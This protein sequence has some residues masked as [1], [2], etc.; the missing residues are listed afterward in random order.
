MKKIRSIFFKL[1]IAL[2]TLTAT[3]FPLLPA[4]AQDMCTLTV[5]IDG[6]G[7]VNPPGGTYES[8]TSINMTAEASDGW[9]FTGWGGAASGTGNPYS[10]TITDNITVTATFE[11]IPVTY[12]LDVNT[13]GS[14]TVTR[15]PDKTAYNPGE[16]V[17]L[18]A[19]PGTGWTFSGWSG[20]ISG[21]TNPA[22]ITMN[23][24]IT[25]TATFTEIPVTY[26]TL[27]T[28]TTGNGGINLDPPGGSYS[29]GTNVTVSAVP[30]PGWT[31]SGWSGDLSGTTNPATITMD[32]NKAVTAAFTQNTYTITTD[33]V[34]GGTITRSPDQASYHYGDIVQ[35][36]AA[37]GAGWTFSSW[38]GDLS[39]TTN[40]ATI[41]IDGNKAVTA[42]FTQNTYTITTDNVGGG[43]ITRSPDQASYHHGDIVQLTAAPGA[44]WSFTSWSGN[45]T[46]S[47]NPLAV[48]V[49]G[50]VS[51]TATFSQEVYP[52]TVNTVGSGSV[53]RSP[54]QASYSYGIPVQLTADPEDGWAFAGWSGNITGNTN[55][56]TFTVQGSMNVTATF[57]QEQYTL[58][59]NTIGNGSVARVPNQAV[60][61]YGTTVQL[62]AVP[63]YDWAF[64]GWGGDING[65]DNPKSF[66]VYQDTV[67]LASFRLS[68]NNGG[69]M[70]GNPSGDGGGSGGATNYGPGTTQISPFINNSGIFMLDR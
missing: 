23:G 7:S 17:Q 42:A 5:T 31:F 55:P 52:L 46:G 37:P 58:T 48:T 47:Q 1:V 13:V 68:G 3:A 64:D 39:G 9:V 36:T 44:G 33:N 22:T 62:S 38:N 24:N 15:N 70:G 32:G 28:S 26:Y 6:Q 35:L 51:V 56:L 41:T 43:T 21:T 25:V 63:T 45:F 2:T 54:D 60:Y 8:G 59:I 20:N 10:L 50:N 11:E 40:P 30:N 34:G 18:T 16:S 29:A 14:G 57:T 4:A 67:V 49:S 53:T 19:N 27:T 61:T 12:S 65:H 69:G 66:T